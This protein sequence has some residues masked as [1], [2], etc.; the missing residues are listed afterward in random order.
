MSEF[1]KGDVVELKSG[2]PKMT[3]GAVG[4]FS[5]DGPIHGAV[6]V[7]FE[8]KNKHEEVFDIDA[9]RIV[10]NQKPTRDHVRMRP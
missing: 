8:G 10:H 5:P 6:C 9:L 4:N 2:G 3:I 1:K 7:W